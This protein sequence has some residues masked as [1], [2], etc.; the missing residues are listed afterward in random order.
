METKT[1]LIINL[2]DQISTSIDS[3]FTLND[4]YLDGGAWCGFKNLLIL[5]NDIDSLRA[6]P[7]F[8]EGLYIVCE[9]VLNH[10]V[11]DYIVDNIEG[12]KRAY[13]AMY[14]LIE[15]L[16]L[17]R[18]EERDSYGVDDEDVFLIKTKL[19]IIAEYMNVRGEAQAII[20]K[21]TE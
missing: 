19:K 14:K 7:S 18:K 20:L 1:K 12:S 13:S 11:A 8:K 4:G 5:S 17:T 9:I 6:N 3:L 10:N 21:E 2:F 15:A 16:E